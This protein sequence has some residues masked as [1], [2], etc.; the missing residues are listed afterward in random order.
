MIIWL[1]GGLVGGVGEEHVDG[2]VAELGQVFTAGVEA[3]EVPWRERVE[4]RLEGGVGHRAD[5]VDR[6]AEVP[7]RLHRGGSR[8]RSTDIE[9]GYAEYRLAAQFR[10]D[11]FLGRGEDHGTAG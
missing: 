4:D 8:L 9:H 2:R 6:G 11:E 5:V 3:A 10:R 1:N 7:E